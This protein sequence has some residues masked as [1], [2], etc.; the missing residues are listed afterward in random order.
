MSSI[1]E[2]YIL[3]GNLNEVIAECMRTNQNNLG[4][5]ISLI[6]QYS[7]GKKVN[8]VMR[9]VSKNV[10]GELKNNIEIF[11]SKDVTNYNPPLLNIEK[12]IRVIMYCNWTSSELLCN[13]WNKMCKGDY[14]WNNIKIVWEE[15]YDYAVVINCPPKGVSLDPSNT[16]VFHMEPNI[17]DHPEIW[18]EWANPDENKFLYVGRHDK[19]YNNNEWHLSKTYSQLSI[20]TVI[21]NDEVSK[22]LSTVLSNKYQDPGHIKRIDF[23]KFLETKEFPVHVY[24]SNDFEWKQYKGSPPS[25]EKDEAMF[26]YKYTF[27]VENFS[28]KGYMTEK[29]FDGILSESLTFYHGCLNIK[30]YIDERAYVWLEL[31]NFENDYLIIKNAIESNLWEERLPFIREAKQKIIN[32]TQFFPRIESIIIKSNQIKL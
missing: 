26:P 21:K 15:P 5:L 8:S 17:P 9:Q 20:E 19:T 27:N 7:K 18:G 3:D 32:E 4:L 25:H 12:K 10:K 29:L 11:H 13:L 16:I 24:G 14:T 22:I 6:L 23:I 30:E 2:K 31:E 1:I 28:K